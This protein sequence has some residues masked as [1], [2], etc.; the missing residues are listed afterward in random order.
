MQRIVM[1]RARIYMLPSD[2]P[3]KMAA[4]SI[5][6]ALDQGTWWHDADAIMRDICGIQVDIWQHFGLRFDQDSD[7]ASKR[8]L[9]QQYKTQVVLPHLKALE[10]DWFAQQVAMLASD[11]IVPYAE[12]LPLHQPW[13]PIERWADW[14]PSQWAML[15]T[16][17]V[18]RVLGRL[19]LLA[20]TGVDFITAL[21]VC[22]F[23]QHPMAGIQHMVQEC[24]SM[25]DVRSEVV[26]TCGQEATLHFCLKPGELTQEGFFAKVK[27]VALSAARLAQQ[28]QVDYV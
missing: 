20:H 16:W 17:S 11:A 8:K 10:R 15:R 13:R 3:T 4:A 23:C 6:G 26:T 18:S 28:L 9:M 12:I 5:M 14:T 25:D 27:L 21:A 1:A 19:P 22:P 24:T 7:T 2:H